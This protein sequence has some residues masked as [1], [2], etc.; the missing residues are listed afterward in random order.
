VPIPP[1]TTTGD[2]PP[3][4]Y[5]ATLT[6]VIE[7]FGRGSAQRQVVAQRLRLIHQIARDTGHLV[8]F[9]VFGSFVSTKARPNEV[10]IFMIMDEGFNLEEYWGDIRLAFE[11]G[12]AQTH[13]GV[14]VFWQRDL[15]IFGSQEEAI[16]AWQITREHRRRGIV[17]VV[18]EEP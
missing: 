18:L 11:H 10:D 1:F 16:E 15:P 6:E 5:R 4:V 3:G 8:R 12:A 13:F 2:L 9:V 17:E 7:R 14:S